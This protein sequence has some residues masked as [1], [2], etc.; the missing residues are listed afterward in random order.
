LCSIGAETDIVG[1]HNI[2]FMS[3]GVV[4]GH[5]RAVV[6]G[7][8]MNTALGKIQKDVQ[9]V[10]ADDTPLQKKIGQ[11][12]TQLQ[13]RCRGVRVWHPWHPRR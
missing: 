9:D 1:K 11:F 12:G 6:Y 4:G 3:T 10:E 2:L 7:T 8:G 13:V 5:A